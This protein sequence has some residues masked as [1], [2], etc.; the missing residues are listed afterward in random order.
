[1][2]RYGGAVPACGGGR[3]AEPAAPL[4]RFRA[5]AASRD[6]PTTHSRGTSPRRPR[7]SFPHHCPAAPVLADPSNRPASVLLHRCTQKYHDRPGQ[8]KVYLKSA[9]VRFGAAWF[10]GQ[11]DEVAV[12]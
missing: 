4:R 3:A 7:P 1:R 6:A 12:G 5:A 11:L 2:P 8:Y 10:G 9:L